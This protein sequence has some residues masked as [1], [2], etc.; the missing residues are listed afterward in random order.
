M[1]LVHLQNT[2]QTKLVKMYQKQGSMLMVSINLFAIRDAFA[3]IQTVDCSD[4]EED[5][6]DTLDPLAT[7]PLI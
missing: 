4:Q 3:E 6:S 2:L 7:L 1:L 5:L